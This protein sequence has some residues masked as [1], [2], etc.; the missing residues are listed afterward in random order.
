MKC[1]HC[2]CDIPDGALAR[3]LAA[4]GGKASGARKCRDVDYGELS[5]KGVAA[6]R[7]KQAKNQKA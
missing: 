6:R 2:A 5:A 1:P 4:K 3:H 7:K